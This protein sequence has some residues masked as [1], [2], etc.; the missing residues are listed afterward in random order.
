MTILRQIAFTALL[1]CCIAFVEGCSSY[2]SVMENGHSAPFKNGDDVIF[3]FSNGSAMKTDGYHHIEFDDSADVIIGTGARYKGLTKLKDFMG[4][5]DLSIVDSIGFDVIWG[6]TCFVCWLND[7]S[8][9]KFKE[10]QYLYIHKGDQKGLWCTGKMYL[11]DSNYKYS[12]IIADKEIT[13]IEIS[14]ASEARMGLLILLLAPVAAIGL[15]L[16]FVPLRPGG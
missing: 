9:L 6:D 1:L 14:R 5:V 2:Q 16:A 4:Q 15:L 8:Y 3:H 12:G 7:G 11:P 10:D 13:D